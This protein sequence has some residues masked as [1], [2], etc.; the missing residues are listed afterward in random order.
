MGASPAIDVGRIFLRQN[1]NVQENLPAVELLLNRP[2]GYTSL[3][4]LSSLGPNK[5]ALLTNSLAFL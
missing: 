3:P 2:T 5:P 4:D 1:R